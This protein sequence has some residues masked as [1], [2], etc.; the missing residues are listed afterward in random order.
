LQFCG[1]AKICTSAFGILSYE[2]LDFDVSLNPDPLS[3][4]LINFSIVS[5]GEILRTSGMFIRVQIRSEIVRDFDF[6][7][8]VFEVLESLTCGERRPTSKGMISEL[9]N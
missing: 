3:H 8:G 4:A 7:D 2:G 9:N 1:R 5:F 6:S